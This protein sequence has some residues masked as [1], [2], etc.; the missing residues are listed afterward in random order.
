MLQ[1]AIDFRDECDALYALLAPLDDADFERETQFKRWTINDIMVHL[2]YWNYG[3]DLSLSNEDEFVALMAALMETLN[4]GGDT[5]AF[6]EDRIGGLTG[7]AL[8]EAWR[9]YYLA[10]ADRFSAA[11]PKQRVKW[12]GPDMSVRSSITARLMETWSHAQAIYDILGVDRQE[13]DRVKNI[14]V[15]GVNT[16]GWTYAV[17]KMPVPE[18]QPYLRL[19]APSGDIWEWNEPS[20]EECVEGSAVEF[21]QGVTQTRNFA[22]TTLSVTGPI[23]NEWMG[24]AQC[25]AGGAEPPPVPGTRF[26]VT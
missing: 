12:A 22:D 19:T 2:H 9:D 1:Q 17:R 3:A 25:F 20:D 26:K 18:V 24:M 8:V 7:R 14:A 10:M 21:C 4:S 5:R 16:F 23:A 11:D 13:A 6:T 15:L